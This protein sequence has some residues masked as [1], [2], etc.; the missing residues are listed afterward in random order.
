MRLG[1]DRDGVFGGDVD[2]TERWMLAQRAVHDPRSHLRARILGGEH[3]A[4]H[5][6]WGPAQDLAALQVDAINLN[7]YVTAKI[8]G[9]K[10]VK[11]IPP[12]DR[13]LRAG[14]LGD[15][16]RYNAPSIA[17]FNVAALAAA[18]TPFSG[19]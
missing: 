15:M 5:L 10:R 9:A 19:G 1:C 13:P 11:Q 16:S 18:T 7:T 4:Q 3:W 2:V 14:A 12:V 8:A 6:G 17:T